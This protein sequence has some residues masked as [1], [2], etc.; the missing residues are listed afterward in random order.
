MQDFYYNARYIIVVCC[1]LFKLYLLGSKKY[2]K[3]KF[4]YSPENSD[5][6]KLEVGDA[7]EI[8][9]EVSKQVCCLL[10]MSITQS[11][12]YCNIKVAVAI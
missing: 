6:L 2:M 3:V 11:N 10:G 9:N 8:L 1:L 5:E 12:Q 4:A 7:I